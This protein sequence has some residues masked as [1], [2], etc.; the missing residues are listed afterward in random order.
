M[1]SD[2]QPLPPLLGVENVKIRENSE[3]SGDPRGSLRDP[4]QPFLDPLQIFRGP[5][6]AKKGQNMVKFA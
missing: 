2:D 4:L 5:M 3:K 1:G 6:G